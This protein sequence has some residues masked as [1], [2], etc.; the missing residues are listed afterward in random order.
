MLENLAP[1][2]HPVHICTRKYQIP[3]SG[4]S[5]AGVRLVAYAEYI[6]FTPDKVSA[7][8]E[9]ISLTPDELFAYAEHMQNKDTSYVCHGVDEREYCRFHGSVPLHHGSRGPR[10]QKIKFQVVR[11]DPTLLLIGLEP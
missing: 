9:Y 1:P 5:S 3:E 10:R 2:G 4:Y 6:N 7:Y 8:T 11:L